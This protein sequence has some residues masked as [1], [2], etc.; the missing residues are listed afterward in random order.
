MPLEEFKARMEELIV[1]LKGSAL[2]QD[3]K[4]IFLP[5]EIEYNLKVERLAKGIPLDDFTRDGL[6][7]AAEA[8]SLPYD[9]ELD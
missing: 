9:I 2:A 3:S 6:R 8:A 7:A 5:G 1:Q 4:G